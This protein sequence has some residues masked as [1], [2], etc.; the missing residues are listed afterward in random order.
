MPRVGRSHSIATRGIASSCLASL[1]AIVLT[2]GASRTAA[3][4]AP[5]EWTTALDAEAVWQGAT[6]AGVLLVGTKAGLVGIDTRSGKRLWRIEDLQGNDATF[7]ALVPAPYGWLRI[8]KGV[9]GNAVRV[10]ID[11]TTGREIWNSSSLGLTDVYHEVCVPWLDRLLIAGKTA[12]G[13]VVTEVDLATGHP[14]REIAVPKTDVQSIFTE[15]PLFDSDTTFVT[16]SGQGL[17]RYDLVSGAVVW[18]SPRLRSGTKVDCAFPDTPEGESGFVV[19]PNAERKDPRPLLPTAPMLVSNDGRQVFTPRGQT[20]HALDSNG[21]AS[22]A[23]RPELC[24]RCIELID[25]ERGVLARTMPELAGNDELAMIDHRLGAILWQYP[26]AAKSWMLTVRTTFGA[27]TLSNPV[28][29]SLSAYVVARDE[30]MRV[31]LATGKATKVGKTQVEEKGVHLRLERNAD[32]FLVIGRQELEWLDGE[33][34]SV[35]RVHYKAPGNLILAAGQL[36]AVAMLAELGKRSGWQ[37]HPL[38]DLAQFPN[39]HLT[40]S[41]PEPLYRA[42]RRSFMRQFH[43][44]SNLDSLL[45]MLADLHE[46][47]IKG[48]AIVW[49]NKRNGEPVR[50]IPVGREPRLEIDPFSEWMFVMDADRIRGYAL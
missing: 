24:G 48:T 42:L 22:W 25:T 36:G 15:P 38:P 8:K 26:T 40:R 29:D 1:L 37:S 49:I 2:S 32:G 13:M 12:D 39:H 21:A 4:E 28:M 43:A 46:A 34:R 27:V 19:A 7:A 23:D 44:T 16:P 3:D 14:L 11:A 5:R 6:P 20:L 10:L 41:S 47:G 50:R 9:R 45:T 35:R 18:A 30:L 17:A 31:D 33:G